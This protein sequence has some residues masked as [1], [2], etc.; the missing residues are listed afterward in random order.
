M[1]PAAQTR[2]RAYKNGRF[3]GAVARPLLLL[4]GVVAGMWERRPRGRG[5]EIQVETFAPLS[6]SQQQMLAAEAARVGAFFGKEASLIV[7][8]LA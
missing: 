1:P 6:D 5:L 3:E 7:S 4:N 8:A 2:I